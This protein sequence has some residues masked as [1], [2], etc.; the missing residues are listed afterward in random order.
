MDSQTTFNVKIIYGTVK[1]EDRFVPDGRGGVKGQSR[2][3]HIDLVGNFV[4]V[5]EW[6]DTGLSMR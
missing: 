1:I 4:S 6:T 2:R 3:L 5:T